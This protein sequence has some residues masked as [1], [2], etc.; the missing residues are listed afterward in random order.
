VWGH[1]HCGRRPA[2]S[3]EQGLLSLAYDHAK[4]LAHRQQTKIDMALHFEPL[5]KN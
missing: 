2:D 1:G 4:K 3:K 5:R